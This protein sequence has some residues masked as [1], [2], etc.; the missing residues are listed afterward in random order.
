VPIQ[1]LFDVTQKVS[2]HGDKAS[3]L[4][5]GGIP[6][7]PGLVLLQIIF[8]GVEGFFNPPATEIQPRDFAGFEMG[9]CGDEPIG[10]L[11]FGIGVFD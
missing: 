9:R 10:G 7:G 5:L 2:G 4:K 8:K 6:R 11:G 3:L 1:H